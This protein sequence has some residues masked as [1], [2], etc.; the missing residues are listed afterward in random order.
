VPLWLQ[1]LANVNYGIKI[2]SGASKDRQA[3]VNPDARGMH[4]AVGDHTDQQLC[5]AGADAMHIHWCGSCIHSDAYPAAGKHEAAV[6]K[7]DG[8]IT[9]FLRWVSTKAS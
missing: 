1:A 7:A 4:D 2:G 5:M 8:T 6:I 3:M 9:F